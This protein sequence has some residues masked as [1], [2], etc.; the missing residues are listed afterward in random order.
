MRERSVRAIAGTTIAAWDA[1]G[2]PSRGLQ[3]AETGPGLKGLKDR[4]Q[5]ERSIREETR[6]ASTPGPISMTSGSPGRHVLGI[7]RDTRASGKKQVSKP[8]RDR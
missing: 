2:R 6:A 4:S 3:H 5:R 1:S 8:G 7:A